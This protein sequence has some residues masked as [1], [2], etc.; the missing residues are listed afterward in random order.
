MDHVV[1]L[2]GFAV[3]TAGVFGLVAG[4]SALPRGYRKRRS[5]NAWPS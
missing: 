4:I 1:V 2:I 3:A 5:G